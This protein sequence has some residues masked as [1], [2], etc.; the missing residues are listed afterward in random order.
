VHAR[1][2]RLRVGGLLQRLGAAHER[3]GEVDRDVGDALER[4]GLHAGAAGASDVAFD[5]AAAIASASGST[6]RRTSSIDS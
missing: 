5:S 2:R 3:V 4:R 6:S 1:A